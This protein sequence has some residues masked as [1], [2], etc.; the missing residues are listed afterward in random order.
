VDLL[1]ALIGPIFFGMAMSVT[2]QPKE[3][4]MSKRVDESDEEYR[5][6]RAEAERLRRQTPEGKEQIQA[7]RQTDEYKAQHA[8]EERERRKSKQVQA[9]DREYRREYREKN[10]ERVR[11]L[12]RKHQ[13]QRRAKLK[14]A[15]LPD[16]YKPTPEKQKEYF[17]AWERN[18]PQR[19]MI[20]RS[21]SSAR[22][23]RIEH[24]ITE[25]D[26]VWHTHCPVLGIELCYERDKRTPHRDNYPTLDRWDNK[27]GYVPGNVFVI[28]WRANRIKWHCSSEELQAVARYARDGLPLTLS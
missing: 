13:Q 15:G 3:N 9:Y 1:G 5:A 11:E 2:N 12:G 22:Q 10:R 19:A 25:S 17:Q 21:R 14:A 26:L 8:A 27:R 20:Q 18:N 28:S 24:T 23:R 7:Y 16:P 4:A 6:R